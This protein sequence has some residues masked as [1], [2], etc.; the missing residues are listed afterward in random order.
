MSQA[1]RHTWLAALAATAVASA[2]A[3]DDSAKAAP[4][5]P[6]CEIAVVSPVT[7]FAEC[8]KPRGAAVDPPPPRPPPT[9]EQ[10]AQHAD[11][12]LN[13]CESVS[14]GKPPEG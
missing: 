9:A 4:N 12:D 11:L 10:C 2:A 5:T 14:A 8:V 3:G 7:G 13:E 6:R 1:N